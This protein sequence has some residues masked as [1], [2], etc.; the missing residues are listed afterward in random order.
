M[1]TSVAFIPQEKCLQYCYSTAMLGH[2]Q[3]CAP[4]KPSQILDGHCRC[5]YTTALTLP[6]HI[7][8]LVLW[9][10]AC[11]DTVTPMMRHWRTS[12]PVTTEKRQQLFTRWKYSC[13]KVEED[14]TK[15]ATTLINKYAFRNVVVKFCEIFTFL[16]REQHEPK[17]S[18]HSFL[19]ASC[20]ITSVV[21]SL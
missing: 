10:K 9:K 1:L 5:I 13:S 12:L 18:R 11:E 14:S 17:S 2:T 3:V 6:Y 20:T 8:C 7:I 19:T 21:A 16:T 15:M 4:E